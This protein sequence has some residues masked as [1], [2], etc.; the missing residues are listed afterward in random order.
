MYERKSANFSSQ[1]DY[2]SIFKCAI[3]SLEFMENAHVCY[4]FVGVHHR[5]HKHSIL[6]Q[7][8]LCSHS[9]GIQEFTAWGCKC[10]GFRTVHMTFIRQRDIWMLDHIQEPKT[11]IDDI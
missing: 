1:S 9:D 7:M 8:Q 3:S 10:L 5:L 6:E 4:H 2:T 11:C